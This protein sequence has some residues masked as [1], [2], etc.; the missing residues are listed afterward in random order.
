M[1]SAVEMCVGSAA[2][3]FEP[4]FF[5]GEPQTDTITSLDLLVAERLNPLAAETAPVLLRPKRLH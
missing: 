4:T 3:G 2:P 5:F 1:E